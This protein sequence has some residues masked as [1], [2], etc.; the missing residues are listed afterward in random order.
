MLLYL[1]WSDKKK[2]IEEIVKMKGVMKSLNMD[3]GRK[4]YEDAIEHEISTTGTNITLR[5][6]NNYEMTKQKVTKV[7]ITPIH[8]KMRVLS[9]NA[10]APFIE[11]LKAEDYIV[12]R[13]C[14]K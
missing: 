14:K 13:Y 1:P 2:C 5:M 3:I 6:N 10:C 11:G 12:E 7:A 9:N 4:N 8:N